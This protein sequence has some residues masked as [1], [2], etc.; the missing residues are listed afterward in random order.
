VIASADSRVSGTLIPA[1]RAKGRIT[2][3]VRARARAAHQKLIEDT[4]KRYPVDLIHMHSL[5]F[6]EYVPD[7]WIPMLATLHLPPDWY[8]AKVFKHRRPNL[9]L[10]CVSS[11]QERQ[12]PDTRSLLPYVTNGVEVNRFRTRLP[13]SNYALSLGRIC[14]EKGFHLAID[15]AR[16]A[17]TPMLLAGQVFPYAAHEEYFEEEIKPRLDARRQFVGP[18][19]FSKKRRLLSQAQCLLIPS[20]VAETSSLVA[21]EAMAAG[22]PVVAF[23]SG[24]L[25]ELIE[26]GRTGFIVSDVQEM[27][28]AIRSAAKLDSEECRSAARTRFSAEVMVQRY[29]DSYERLIAQSALPA[30]QVRPGPSWLVGWDSGMPRSGARAAEVWPTTVSRRGPSFLTAKASQS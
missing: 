28:E 5:D 19:G 15:A 2:D 16:R 6:H 26:H 18:V 27:A 10:N 9:Y 22:T 29:L 20:T 3:S 1:P 23:R 13:K 8:P 24:A 4:L 12:C 17:R 21:M 14:P 30:N 11:S 7:T 25:P